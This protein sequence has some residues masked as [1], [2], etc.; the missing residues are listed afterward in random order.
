MQK[1][2]VAGAI[3]AG[4]VPGRA[5]RAAPDACTDQGRRQRIQ[6]AVLGDGGHRELPIRADFVG[7]NIPTARSEPC[8]SRSPRSTATTRYASR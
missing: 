4:T 5:C 1:F 3:F 2:P 8:A 7:K 6:L